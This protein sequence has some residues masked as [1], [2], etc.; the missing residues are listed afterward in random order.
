MGVRFDPTRHHYLSAGVNHPCRL[1]ARI[2]DADLGNPLALDTDRP[3]TDSLW[4][5]DIA[6]TN[7]QIEH[8]ALRVRKD[9]ALLRAR[10]GRECFRTYPRLKTAVKR[11]RPPRHAH[12]V[13]STPS[14]YIA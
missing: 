8:D 3:L 14:L 1:H 11:V 12:C 6:A 7:Q 5:N 10:T 9:A 13:A 2:V 4:S